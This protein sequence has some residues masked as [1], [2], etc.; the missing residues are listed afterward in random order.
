MRVETFMAYVRG[1]YPTWDTALAG[2]LLKQFDLPLGRKL[3][4]LS[5]G[6]QMKVALASA[7]A[8][9]PKLIVLDEPFSG[10]DPLVRDEL[11]AALQERTADSTIFVSSHDLAEIEAF[12]NHIGYLDAGRLRFSE[13]MASLTARFRDVE[14]I[15]DTKTTGE[16]PAPG[17]SPD[18]PAT[19]ALPATWLHVNRSARSLRFIDNAF[20]DEHSLADCAR[21]LGT[22]CAVTV[23]PMSLRAIFLALAKVS[24]ETD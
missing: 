13:E 15:F 10:L 2:K 6:T 23:T 22:V 1:F 5:R 18:A 17:Q 7:L 11:C 14:I 19:Q 20:V 4:D 16:P 24:R 8:F 9:R 3:K 21:R 12:A